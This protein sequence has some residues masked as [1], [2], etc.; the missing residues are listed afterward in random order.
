MEALRGT[1]PSS[2]AIAAH[3]EG[4]GDDFDEGCEE[5]LDVGATVE[6][7]VGA[8][9]LPDSRA[10]HLCCS[11]TFQWCSSRCQACVPAR[12]SHFQLNQAA[13]EVPRCAPHLGQ[14]LP[15][16]MPQWARCR[17]L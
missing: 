9:T 2:A 10:L 14:I 7:E 16:I 13:A 6:E 5:Q 8:G 15:L 11:R 4:F 12:C 1:R 17:S 3:I